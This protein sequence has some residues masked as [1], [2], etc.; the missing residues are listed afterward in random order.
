MPHTHTYITDFVCTYHLI[1]GGPG[2]DADAD[3]YSI[4]C[5]YRMQFLQAFGIPDFDN[6]IID[7]ILAEIADKIKDNDELIR[8]IMQHPL[9]ASPDTINSS[10]VDILPFLFAYSSFYAFHKCLID[11]YNAGLGSSRVSDE[12]LAAL[13]GT[14]A[15]TMA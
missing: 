12:N 5:L 14:F 10:Y 6:V 2:D 11:V 15:N 13:A 4:D 1:G 7:E 8:V 9:L 3:E